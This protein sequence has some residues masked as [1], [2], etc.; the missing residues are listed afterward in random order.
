MTDLNELAR[1]LR[2]IFES[3]GRPGAGE[4]SLGLMAEIYGDDVFFQDP[5]QTLNGKEALLAM[6]KRFLQRAKE[7]RTEI[8]EVQAKGSSIFVVW[9][10]TYVPRTGPTLVLDGT[11]HAQVRDGKIVYHRDYWDL[12]GSVLGSLPWVAPLYKKIVAKLG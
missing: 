11:S 3:Y 9:T 2:S 6:S 7:M 12:L 8:H 10:I 4:E 1:K 5:L